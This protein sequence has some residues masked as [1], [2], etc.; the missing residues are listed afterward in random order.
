MYL[1][2]LNES[3]GTQAAFGGNGQ[4]SHLNFYSNYTW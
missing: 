3:L 2:V 1:K 4:E